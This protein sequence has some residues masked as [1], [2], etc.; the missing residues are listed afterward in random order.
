MRKHQVKIAVSS[1]TDDGQIEHYE[2]Y[3]DSDEFYK[4]VVIAME[5]LMK[6]YHEINVDIDGHRDSDYY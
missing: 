3:A 6:K 2:S 4:A 5:M 1:L